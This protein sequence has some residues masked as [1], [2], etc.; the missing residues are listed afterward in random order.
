M[1]WGEWKNVY[2]WA[3]GHGYTFSVT[4]YRSGYDNLPA[5]VTWINALKWCNAK[6]EKEGLDPVYTSNGT[7]L[8][9]GDFVLPETISSISTADG[10]RIPTEA[11]WEW[12]ARGGLNSNVYEY[13]GSNDID[14]VAWWVEISIRLGIT[15]REVGTKSSNKLG[16]HDMSGNLYEYCWD[17]YAEGELRIRGG[18]FN[19]GAN[20][21]KVKSRG[22]GVPMGYQGVGFRL[23]RNVIPIKGVWH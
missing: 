12:A 1:T 19:S 18:D 4:G 7:V 9:E 14:S 6:S 21:C 3:L 15:I 2:D 8:R 11:E 20:D 5:W 16:I 13:S 17:W 10:Y 23:A 22:Y